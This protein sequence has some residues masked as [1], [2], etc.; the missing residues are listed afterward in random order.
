MKVILFG[1]GGRMGKE[2][3]NLINSGDYDAELVACVDAF[4]CEVEGVPCFKTIDEYTGGGDVII[5]FSFHGLTAGVLDYAKKNQI[6][7]MI[8]TTGHTAEELA[9][10]TEASKS[11]AVFKTANMSLGVAVLA[12]LAKEAAKMFPTADIEIIEKHHNRKLDVP[13]GTALLLADRIK[14]AR[15]E[16]VYNIGRHENGKRT[17]QEIGIHAIRMGNEVGTHEI[18]ISTDNQVITLKHEAKSR[19]LFAEGAVSAAAYLV[20]KP[21]GLYNMD[22]LVNEG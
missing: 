10:I 20:G 14:E 1:A 12:S 17:K 15:T 6:P 18:I 7:A 5:D 3:I 9:T 2:V 13:S 22:D 21:A 19:A 8:A 16:A 11:V 4:G